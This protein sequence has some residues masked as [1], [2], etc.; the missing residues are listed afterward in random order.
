MITVAVGGVSPSD[1]LE[2]SPFQKKGAG[3]PHPALFL[4]YNAVMPIS[5]QQL[6]NE[7]F[8][9]QWMLERQKLDTIK[10][11]D[12]D[13]ITHNNFMWNQEAKRVKEKLI[14]KYG[15]NGQPIKS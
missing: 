9:P 2:I 7:P 8:T 4:F 10:Q 14:N 6:F 15:K 12:K 13:M 5:N 1:T 11:K 3:N